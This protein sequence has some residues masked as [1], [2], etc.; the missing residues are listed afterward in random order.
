MLKNYKPH[1]KNSLVASVM[2]LTLKTMALMRMAILYNQENC[3]L[4]HFI[5]F[6]LEQIGTNRSK[7]RS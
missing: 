2:I 1:F 7:S 5:Y 6:Y 4:K 3:Q